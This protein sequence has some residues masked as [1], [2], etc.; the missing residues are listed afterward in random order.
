[1]KLD[2]QDK[3]NAR[4]R[5]L[6]YEASMAIEGLEVHPDDRPIVAAADNA[7]TGYEDG[8]R[9]M[10]DHLHAEGVIPSSDVDLAAE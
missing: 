2:D 7:G 5:G 10:I 8:V 6:A 3:E 9:R 4:Q 1:M